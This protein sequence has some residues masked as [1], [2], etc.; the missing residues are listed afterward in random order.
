MPKV[1]SHH[2]MAVIRGTVYVMGGHCGGSL[3]SIEE[4]S[5][6]SGR[7]SHTGDLQT[8]TDE[9]GVTALGETIL[10]VGGDT[11]E[12]ERLIQ[13]F[14]VETR[15]SAV[16]DVRLPRPMRHVRAASLGNTAFFVGS[17][18]DLVQI[19]EV[20]GSLQMTSYVQLA[21]FG[22]KT[23]FG[24]SVEDGCVRV[25]GG[26]ESQSVVCWNLQGEKVEPCD[27]GE[28]PEEMD[29]CAAFLAEV[30]CD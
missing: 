17:E 4:Y 28:L 27:V 26:D 24:L 6:E 23:W 21:G 14:N 13:T 29:V 3:T 22:R 7:W 15:T 18:G 10:V 5:R 19:S 20:E 8:A 16:L 25:M 9:C 11:D 30:P 2:G 12:A 1:R